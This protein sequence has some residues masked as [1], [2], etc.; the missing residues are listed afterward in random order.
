MMKLTILFL[1]TLLVASQARQWSRCEIAYGRNIDTFLK[2]ICFFF[3]GVCTA[4][5]ESS[6]RTEALGGPNS[7]GTYD[8]GMFQV[9]DN[10]WCS[11]SSVPGKDCNVRC[12]SLRDDNLTD[13]VACIRLIYNRH[14]FDAWYG[15]Q[16]RCRG[17]DVSQ[18][19]IGCGV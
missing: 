4:E 15:W 17:Q 13:D 16:A 18:Y 11:T 10:Y 14:G 6:R 9:N 8:H 5:A 2:E 1:S 7:D 3:E 19:L 12:D